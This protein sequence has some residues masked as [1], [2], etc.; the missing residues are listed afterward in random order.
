MNETTKIPDQAKTEG[1]DMPKAAGYVFIAISIFVGLF[2]ALPLLAMFGL[3]DSGGSL[4]EYAIM[5][6]IAAIPLTGLI[7]GIRIVSRKDPNVPPPGIGP[8]SIA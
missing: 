7:I 8:G 5:F 2:V 3:D 6:I 4:P 1:E